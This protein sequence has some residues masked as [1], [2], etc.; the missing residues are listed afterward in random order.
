[1][2]EMLE[3][4]GEDASSSSGKQNFHLAIERPLWD[5]FPSIFM[6]QLIYLIKELLASMSLR[7]PICH[8]FYLL[9]V[10]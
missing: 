7:Q 1:M 2:E 6:L 10:P 4:K 3:G 5:E 8:K 9:G